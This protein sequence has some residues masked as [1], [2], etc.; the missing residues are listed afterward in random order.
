MI[1]GRLT[2]DVIFVDDHVASQTEKG[3][4]AVLSE[5]DTDYKITDRTRWRKESNDWED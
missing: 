4:L 2:L 5:Q 1:D 3:A